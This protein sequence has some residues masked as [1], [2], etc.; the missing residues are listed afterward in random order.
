MPKKKKMTLADFQYAFRNL[1][2]QYWIPSKS[3]SPTGIDQTLEHVL[4]LKGKVIVS[5]DLGNVGLKAYRSES[6]SLITLF[7][8]NHKVWRMKPS[9]FESFPNTDAVLMI[10]VM[11][12]ACAGHV[13]GRLMKVLSL[14]T[15]KISL[16]SP[17]RISNIEQVMLRQTAC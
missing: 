12:S 9:D 1:G 13:I 8:F 10:R 5:P 2:W 4:G 17:P 7:T 14:L 11:E 16:W 15:Q 3:K 6:S